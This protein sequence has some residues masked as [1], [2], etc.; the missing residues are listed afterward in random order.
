MCVCAYTHTNT[1]FFPIHVENSM[2]SI[3]RGRDY[4]APEW[5]SQLS[6]RLLISGQVMI[7]GSWDLA[8]CWAPH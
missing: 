4:E 5:F 8:L 6:V 2:F 3:T 7:P 1:Y